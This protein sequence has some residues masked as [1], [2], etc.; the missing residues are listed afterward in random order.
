M[1][2]AWTLGMLS[3][4]SSAARRSLAN[5][6][7]ILKSLAAMPAGVSLTWRV[8]TTAD[9]DDSTVTAALSLLCQV[10]ENA[11]VTD[12]SLVELESISSVALASGWSL[13]RYGPSET[14]SPRARRVLVPMPGCESLPIKPDWVLLFDLLRHRGRPLIVDVVCRSTAEP[15]RMKAESC[16]PLAHPD[17]FDFDP[18]VTFLASLTPAPESLGLALELVVSSKE[19]LDPVLEQH[20]GVQLLG[21]P[22]RSMTPAQAQKAWRATYAPEVALRAWHAP[23]GR[24]QGRGIGAAQQRIS[25]AYDLSRSDGAALGTAHI[26]GPDWD[27]AAPVRIPI[28]ERLRHI[29]IVGKT[30]AGKTNLMKQI[31][32]QDIQAGHG[33]AVITPHGDLIDH[34]V[35][36][37]R[38]RADEIVL[39][40]FGDE[41]HT[42][43][44]NPLTLDSNDDAEFTA[45]LSRFIDLVSHQSFNQWTGP[46]F[47]DS[48]RLAFE[49]AGALVPMIGPYPTIAAGVDI[50]K[51]DKLQRWACSEVRER[52]PDLADDWERVFNMRGAEAAETSRWV[53][54]K[55]SDFG[56]HSAMRLITTQTEP[57]S[58]SLREIYRE[59]KILLVRVPDTHVSGSSASL[60]GSFIFNR[61]FGEAQLAGTDAATPFYI[62]VDEFQRFVSAD[63]EELVAEARK[64]H[65]G[66]TFAHQNLS[67]LEAFSTYEG[68]TNTRLADAIFSN[69]G[70]LVM[71]KT[72]GRDVPRFASELSLSETQVRSVA[73]GHAIVRTGHAGEDVTCSVRIPLAA[74]RAQRGARR[75]L[76]ERMI[77]EGYWM[78]RAEQDIRVEQWLTG[79]RR[80]AA[81]TAEKGSL[82]ARQGKPAPTADKGFLD[83]WLAKRQKS[84][85]SAT[86]PDPSDK[87]RRASPKR[88]PKTFD[89]RNDEPTGKAS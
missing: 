19:T 13:S 77:K 53:T 62:H 35:D 89:P 79:L 58:L 39:L 45:N 10:D 36:T 37:A 68:R 88:M 49:T 16:V 73:R 31:A 3:F 52:R 5:E 83:E 15:T 51:S 65:V 59:G 54:S 74:C 22:V 70:T 21:V 26:E 69:V 6:L 67:Q 9:S 40:D 30:G 71:M 42:P 23:Y 55:F 11:E 85:T 34:L 81:G 82:A 80:Q 60:L 64:F 24:L 57:C 32:Q 72:A 56:T 46:V 63:L 7:L 61:L 75:R 14:T 87:Q 78:P 84:P 25:A 76:R 8:V 66:L 12:E 33:V 43:V 44:V 28:E 2:T 29:Y 50:V 1:K 38:D 41:T 47:A 27:R 4:S 20:L 17:A 18:G 48:V 86:R